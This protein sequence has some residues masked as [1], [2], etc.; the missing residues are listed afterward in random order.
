M[1]VTLPYRLHHHQNG[2]LHNAIAKTRN[3]QWPHFA[4]RFRNQYTPRWQRV[5]RPRQQL[6]TDRRKF[7]VEMLLH[8]CL[9][10]AVDARRLGSAGGQRNTSRFPEPS[11]VG[12][13][14]QE[15]VE[16]A[17]IVLRRPCRQF[18]L[19]F[20]DYQRSSPHCGQLIDQANHLNCPPSHVAGF[21]GLGLLRRLRQLAH[22]RGHTPL[23]SVQTFP[24]SHAGLNAWARLP[25][26]AFILAFRK[27]ARMSWPSYAL[28]MTP[29]RSA[30]MSDRH[31]R[32]QVIRI[33]EIDPRPAC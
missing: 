9:V 3:A 8:L 23:A 13:Q 4:V 21:P 20:T 31:S 14:P 17:F 28:S 33:T 10:D 5:V 15:T 1:E 6:R 19:H 18:A 16:L 29:C 27:S 25:I 24:S 2:P 22:H 30:Y 26:A 11:S 32:F 7:S 12:D